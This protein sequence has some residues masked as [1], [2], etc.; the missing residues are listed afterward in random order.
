MNKTTD[1]TPLRYCIGG[2]WNAKLEKAARELNE[3]SAAVRRARRELAATTAPTG[4]Q[5]SK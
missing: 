1:N 5:V 4:R 2:G 3:A